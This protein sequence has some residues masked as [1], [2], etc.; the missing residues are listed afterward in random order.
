MEWPNRLY[1]TLRVYAVVLM[2]RDESSVATYTRVLYEDD[3]KRAIQAY[4]GKAGS[5]SV[6]T[7]RE[8]HLA[9]RQMI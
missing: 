4:T 1:Y 7:F 2:S 3:G 5:I 8:F 6:I 9:Q